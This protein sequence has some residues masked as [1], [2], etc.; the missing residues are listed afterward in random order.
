[1]LIKFQNGFLRAVL[2]M[3]VHGPDARRP[4]LEGVSEYFP[5]PDIF[6]FNF[7]SCFII[8]LSFNIYW[9]VK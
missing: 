6:I 4:V 5:F 9:Y 3:Y 2:T 1:M 7:E 8:R